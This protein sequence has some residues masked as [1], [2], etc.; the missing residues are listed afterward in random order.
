[1][2]STFVIAV[3]ALVLEMVIILISTR[4]LLKRHAAGKTKTLIKYN[5]L[6]SEE[7]SG[8]L[9]FTDAVEEA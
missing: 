3:L 2:F 5:A 8:K 7:D 4:A 1:M 6:M 9:E